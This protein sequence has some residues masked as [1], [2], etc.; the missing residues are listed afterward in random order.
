MT[1]SRSVVYLVSYSTPLSLVLYLKRAQSKLDVESG[2]Y[3]S[4]LRQEGKYSVMHPK[5][6]NEKEGGFSQPPKGKA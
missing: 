2:C 4:V 1:L 3:P 6:R 5:Q